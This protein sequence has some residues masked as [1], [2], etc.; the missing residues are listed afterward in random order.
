MSVNDDTNTNTDDTNAADTSSKQTDDANNSADPKKLAEDLARSMV[1]EQLK[2]IKAKLDNAFSSR[3]EALKKLAEREEADRQAEL[4]RLQEEGKHKEAFEMQ[5]AEERAKREALEKTNIELTRDLRLKDALKSLPFRNDSASEMAY[6]EIVSQLVR[7]E[8]GDWVHRTGLSISEFV[9]GFSENDEN[10]FLF[11]PVT[12]SGSGTSS[13]AGTP[14][15]SSEK[16][17]L[18]SMSTQE[19]LKLASEGKL[20]R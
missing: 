12:S 19:V 3:D 15:T 7:N 2:E 11:K 9:K 1:D 8:Q 6:R 16:K 18:F 4:K 13:A 10:S 14:P 5:L 17:S 20:K